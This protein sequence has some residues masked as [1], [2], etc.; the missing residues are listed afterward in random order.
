[1]V[2]KIED[3]PFATFVSKP[4]ND[5]L[6]QISTGTAEILDV[7]GQRL[8]AVE[9]SMVRSRNSS[10]K[11]LVFYYPDSDLRGVPESAEYVLFEA[12]WQQAYRAQGQGAQMSIRGVK[13]EGPG[14][15]GVSSDQSY[16]WP[17]AKALQSKFGK[18]N[19]GY[20]FV[21]DGLGFKSSGFDQP[22]QLLDSPAS[23]ESNY[24]IIRSNR[25]RTT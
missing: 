23:F 2:Q 15:D 3:D 25:I 16:C 11:N 21:T 18:L 10:L 8:R 12:D 7:Y 14:T 1:M 13:K 5:V 24:T 17:G 6:T 22:L 19:S 4:I 20:R 9:T